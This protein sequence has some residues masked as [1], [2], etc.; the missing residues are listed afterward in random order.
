RPCPI[1]RL[2]PQAWS[3]LLCLRS[4]GSATGYYRRDGEAPGIL[5]VPGGRLPERSLSPQ[6]QGQLYRDVDAGFGIQQRAGSKSHQERSARLPCDKP[7]Q[8][9]LPRL[10]AGGRT[11][12]L[13]AA[14]A[15]AA[16]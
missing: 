5:L 3:P 12:T 2:C 7:W 10:A 14:T 15:D 9:Q 11:S 1:C 6:R 13:L 8:T 16:G 4:S